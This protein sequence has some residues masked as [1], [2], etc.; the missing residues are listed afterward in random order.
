[1]RRRRPI[2][3]EAEERRRLGELLADF[4]AHRI[5]TWRFVACQTLAIAGW[6]AWNLWGPWRVDPAPFI[7]LNL[8]LSLQAAYTGPVLLISANRSSAEDRALM[9]EAIRLLKAKEHGR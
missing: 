6:I 2:D 4:V 7:G 9:R 3:E 8:L 5:G 1:M